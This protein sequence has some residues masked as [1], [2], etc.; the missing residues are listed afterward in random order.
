MKPALILSCL[1]ALATGALASAAAAQSEPGLDAIA[2]L[3]RANGLAL[4]CGH[5]EAAARI[6]A[7]MLRHAPKTRSYGE[8]YEEG[9]QQAFKAVTGG[10]EACPEAPMVALRADAAIE[11]VR[12]ALPAA[13]P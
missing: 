13:A 12:S 2:T 11:A 9:A 7:A 3:G 5:Q 8:A 6:K 10:R 4:A 1:A